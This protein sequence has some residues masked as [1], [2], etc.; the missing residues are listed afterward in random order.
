LPHPTTH[1]LLI[2]PPA[3]KA[4]EPPAGIARLAGA[5]RTRGIS[6]R[7]I[8]ANRDGQFWI[9]RQ[10]VTTGDTSA[11]RAGLHAHRNLAALQDP[12]VYGSPDRY[13]QAVYELNRLLEASSAPGGA[14][15]T[16]ANFSD[17]DFSPLRTGD[18]SATAGEDGHNPFDPYFIQEL[19]P[20]VEE[21]SPSMVGIS[22]SFLSQ[23]LGAFRIAGLLKHAFPGMKIVFGGGLVTTWLQNRT[24]LDALAHL[25]DEWVAGPGEG[26]L[27]ELAGAEAVHDARPDYTDLFAA[28]Y[29][30][31]GRVLPFSASSGCFWRKCRFC[32]ENAEKRP[33]KPMSA[34]RVLDHL[35][36]LC[37]DIG[38][39]LIHFL[40]NALHP[41]LVDALIRNPLGIPWYGFSR[42]HERLADPAYGDALR[43]SGCVMLK[44]GL[45]SGDQ[46][47]LDSMQKGIRLD[48][49]RDILRNLHR[50]GVGTYVYLLFGTPSEDEAA[51]ERT[52]DFVREHGRFIDFLNVAI[53]NLPVRSP[54]AA[55]LRV[56]PFFKGDLGMYLDFDHPRGW[57]RRRVRQFLDKHF[58]RDPA[59]ARILRRDPPFFTSNHAPFLV[60]A[61]GAT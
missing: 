13:G 4:C 40:D 59:V 2:H 54:D 46:D 11:R 33:W 25:V 24:P 57:E 48:A 36:G 53:F 52:L 28:P 5:L 27:L 7:V 8:D 41:A 26:R 10:E 12:S 58:R 3:A 39:R 1:I 38:P 44:L 16:L 55:G 32:P 31:P 43:R 20:A 18:L 45:E 34:E 42:F 14:R 56:R 50:S 61:R 9:F 29:L 21:A 22:V 17:P 30:S 35:R 23:A 47:V 60:M 15:A 37:A 49:A 51:A 6:C 19:L